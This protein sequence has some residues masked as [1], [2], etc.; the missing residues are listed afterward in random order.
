M[1]KPQVSILFFLISFANVLGLLYAAALPDLTAYFQVTKAAAQKTVSFYLLGALLAQIIYAPLA[2]A[3]GRKPTLYIGCV[4]AILGSALCLIAIDLHSFPLLLFA[5]VM[6]ACGAASG[7][8]LTNTI[9]SDSFSIQEQKKH[10]SYLMSGFAI[11]PALAVTFGGFITES[12]SWIG[13]FYVTLLYSVFV[14]SLC[15]FLPETGKETGFHHLHPLK[16]LKAYGKQFS[17]VKPFLYMLIVSCASL[18]LYVFSA[19]APFIALHQLKISANHFGLYNLIPNIG[20]FLGGI[21]SA[22]L[23][24]RFSSQTL[25]FAGGL[26]F[27]LFSSAMWVLFDVGVLNALT[28]FGIPLLIFLVTPTILSQGQAS[29]LA[30]STDKVYA[31]SALYMFQFSWVFLSITSLGLFPVTDAAALPIVYS[32]SGGLILLLWSGTHFLRFKK[33]SS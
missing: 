23:S 18:I 19:E 29:C 26:G 8:I 33:K 16:I 3:L 31:S 9:L 28:L 7:L 17:S 12:L 25:I 20:L 5:R 21:A 13:C 11:L 6:T 24:H 30:G 22:A 2:K 32:V 1:K 10:L 14:T 27:F 4:V 15:F